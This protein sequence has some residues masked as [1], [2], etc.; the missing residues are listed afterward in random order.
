MRTEFDKLVE[1]RRASLALLLEEQIA[2]LKAAP[3]NAGIELTDEDKKTVAGMVSPLEAELSSAKS[4]TSCSSPSEGVPAKSSNQA[5]AKQQKQLQVV[6]VKDTGSANSATGPATRSMETSD[7]PAKEEEGASTALRGG[8]ANALPTP[9]GRVASRTDT[10]PPGGV[11]GDPEPASCDS[12]KPPYFGNLLVAGLKVL[13]G[14]PGKVPASQVLE[15]VVYKQKKDKC[16]ADAPKLSPTDPT[17]SEGGLA[18]VD[19]KTGFFY[20]ELH[21]P[22]AE[23]Q[24]VCVW[25]TGSTDTNV[26]PT[27]FVV[28]RWG[29]HVSG[30]PIGRTRYFLEAGVA[31]SQSNQQFSNQ[32]LYL[33]FD[34]DRNWIRGTHNALFNS[35]FSASLTSIPVAA[36]S[37]T[38]TTTTTGG[39]TTTTPANSLSTFMSARKAAVVEG[40]LY[41]PLY[42]DAFKGWFGSGTTA[43]V[44]PIVKGGLQT[45]TQGALSS[46]NPAPGT[47]TT[48]MTVNN[49]GL[50]YFWGAGVRLG[51]LKLHRSWNIAPLML[52]HIDLTVGQWEN[53]KQC[54]TRTT[55][56]CP[57][58]TNGAVT[59]GLY[60]PLLFALEGHIGIPKTPAE[61]GFSSIT[62]INGGGQGD[63]RFFFGVKLDIGCFT[64]AV[65]SGGG[66]GK[67]FDCSEDQQT[68]ATPANH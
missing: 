44:A 17:I 35:E 20:A 7:P 9:P 65:T 63:L 13:T 30:E 62:P 52:S 3:I 11:N 45:I 26:G 42:A 68:S 38:M 18:N 43:F 57:I 31:L 6:S 19:P 36:T 39:T 64:K 37:T 21:H 25:P 32:D 33:S 4:P 22:L 59:G 66:A 5:P 16:E 15:V 60:E 8:A 56:A 53:F 50:Y 29:Y 54:R 58:G 34:L 14:C 67:L 10:P 1:S 48:S 46:S 2:M 49:N 41:A 61:I 27:P 51:D 55:A 23:E 40:A 47:S 28:Y 12:D 24:M